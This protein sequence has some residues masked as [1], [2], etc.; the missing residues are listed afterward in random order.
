VR[1]VRPVF[2]YSL[3]QDLHLSNIM[4]ASVPAGESYPG[5][6]APYAARVR[7]LDRCFGA[8]VDFLKREQLYDRSVI[9]LTSDH[10]EML[11]EA[12]RWGHA[13]YLFPEILRVPLII[14]LPAGVRPGGRIDLGALTFTTDIAPTLYAALGYQ[15]RASNP[16]MGQSVTPGSEE[17]ALARRRGVSVV[18]A[19]YSPVYGVV[20]RNGRRVYI[21]D[22]VSNSEYAYDR[23]ASGTWRAIAID[24]G[25][26][27]INQRVI[28]EHIDTIRRV[29]RMDE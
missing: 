15:P 19:S 11:G 9:V 13:Y 17:S 7:R 22:A 28:R 24:K 25:M 6:H 5:F 26:R 14:H 1:S 29:Y 21:I 20:R 4:T 27:T 16:L 18:A 3:P 8:F 10:G 23:D 2:G 12:G